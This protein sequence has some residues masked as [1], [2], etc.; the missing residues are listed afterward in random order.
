MNWEV[1]GIIVEIIGV[2]VVVP[3]VIY[4]AIQTRQNTHAV[5]ASIR[6]SMLEEDCNF[7]YKH[8][9]FPFTNPLLIDARELTEEELSQAV[10]SILAFVRSR[11]SHWLQFKNGV[12]DSETWETYRTPMIDQLTTKVGRAIWN[13]IVSR[14]LLNKKFAEEVN[15]YLDDIKPL[16]SI[17]IRE[18]LGLDTQIKPE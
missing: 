13:F 17:S 2:L 11:E 14:K 10:I 3:T 7:L 15:T 1:I 4:L 12:I 8:Q 18:V 9:E 5:Q 6:Q 16:P